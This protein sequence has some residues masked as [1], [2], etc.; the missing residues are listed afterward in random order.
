MDYLLPGQ[1]P[2]PLIQQMMQQPFSHPPA[3]TSIHWHITATGFPWPLSLL[4]P[5]VVIAALA[6]YLFIRTVIY[7]IICAQTQSA[8]DALPVKE[9]PEHA[10]LLWLL[11]IPVVPFVWNYFVFLPLAKAYRSYF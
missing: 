6:I 5:A 9:R 10:K 11:M 7:W 8:I 4:S 2:P 1:T 3:P